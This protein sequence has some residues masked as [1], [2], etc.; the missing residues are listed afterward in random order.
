[1]EFKIQTSQGFIEA[2]AKKEELSSERH[3]Q[4]IVRGN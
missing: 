4:G 1:M 2:S 3:Q